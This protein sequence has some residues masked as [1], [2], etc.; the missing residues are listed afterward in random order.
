MGKWEENKNEQ[1][2]TFG[3]Y[4]SDLLSPSAI[5]QTFGWVSVRSVC[6]AIERRS[7]PWRSICW[8]AS[9]RE[10]CDTLCHPCLFWGLGWGLFCPSLRDPGLVLCRR[11]HL[12]LAVEGKSPPGRELAKGNLCRGLNLR[13]EDRVGCSG[14]MVSC[15]PETDAWGQKSVKY[16]PGRLTKG[17]WQ[18]R[19][20]CLGGLGWTCTYREPGYD[21]GRRGASSALGATM[22]W[23]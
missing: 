15:V 18:S 4:W 13:D 1:E 7:S 12:S 16:Y 5:F 14:G 17:S 6:W 9:Q 10:Q 20:G 19:R 22:S 11:G 21:L 2:C 3:W 23:G 8:R